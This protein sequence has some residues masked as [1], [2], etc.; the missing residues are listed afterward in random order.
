VFL[1]DDQELRSEIVGVPTSFIASLFSGTRHSIAHTIPH[2]ATFT[3][4]VASSPDDIIPLLL[5]L[6][7]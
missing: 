2:G 6:I 3:I 5:A 4:E 1:D 7:I